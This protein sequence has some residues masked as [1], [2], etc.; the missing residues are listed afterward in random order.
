MNNYSNVRTRASRI[1]THGLTIAAVVLLNI[2][3]A[4][5]STITAGAT[6]GSFDVSPTGAASYNIPI[7]VPPGIAGIAPNLSLNYNSLSGNGLVGMD[8]SIGGLSVITRCP[9]TMAQDGIKEGIQYDTSDVYCLDGQRLVKSSGTYGGNGA[10]YRTERDSFSN[11][12]SYGSTGYGPAWFKVQ[13]KSGQTFEYGHT[14]DSNIMLPGAGGGP[15][16]I[17]YIWSVSKLSDTVGNYLTI[18]YQNDNAIGQYY[19]KRIDYTGNP[20]IIA[21]ET[22]ARLPQSHVDFIYNNDNPVDLRPDIITWYEAGK[23]FNTQVRL[24]NVK[25]YTKVAGVDT[26][27]KNYRLTYESELSHSTERSRLA[28]IEECDGAG[29]VCLNPS[30]LGWQDGGMGFTY[31]TEWITAY[32]QNGWGDDNVTPR[33]LA[34]V[35]GDSLPDIVGFATTG[36]VVSLGTGTGFD[37]PTTWLANAFGANNIQSNCGTTSGGWWQPPVP[38]ITGW[39]GQGA[40]PRMMRDLN[41]DGKADILGFGCSGVVVSYANASGSGFTTPVSLITGTFGGATTGG[42]WGANSVNPRTL[43]DVDG[44]GRPD[45]VGFGPTGVVVSLGTDTGFSTPTPWLSGLGSASGWGTNSVNPRMLSD[46]NGDGKDDIVGFA[47]TGVYV[48]LSTGSPDTGFTAATQWIAAYGQNGW[49]NNSVN[50]RMLSDVNGDG[51]SDIVGF[52]WA[53]VYVSLST[54][55]GFTTATQWNTNYGQSGWANNSVNPRMLVDVNGDGKADIVGFAWDGVYVSL[56]TGST[57]TGFTTAIQWSQAYGQNGWANNTVNPRMLVDVNGDGLPD[58]LG[59][60]Y[61]GTY[62]STAGSLFPD[63][64][65]S[66][67]NGLGAEA[68]ISYKPITDDSVYTMGSGAVYPIR[69]IQAPIYVVSSTSSSNGIGG[70]FVTDYSYANAKVDLSG[71][72]HLGFG[73]TKASNAQSNTTLSTTYNQLYP[74]TGSPA[75]QTNSSTSSGQLLSNTINTYSTAITVA[76]TGTGTT[77]QTPPAV[78]IGMETSEQTSHDLNGA[79]ISRSKTTN[80]YDGYGNPTNISVDTLN[81]MGNS[82]GYNKTTVNTYAPPDLVKWFLS[83]LTNATVSSTSPDEGFIPGA[84]YTFTQTITNNTENY[85]FRADAI[86]SGW[87]QVAPLNA[88]VTVNDGVVIS[89]SSIGTYAFTV[90]G[91]YPVGSTINLLIDNGAY[92][93]GKGGA[94]G[95]GG[96]GVG[97]ASILTAAMYGKPGGPAL[98]I[99]ATDANVTITNNG[100]IAGGG[101]GGGGGAEVNN[102]GSVWNGGGGGGGG[103]GGGAGGQIWGA[104]W[105]GLHVYP[106]VYGNSMGYTCGHPGL[107][108]T[109]IA[110]GTGGAKNPS[111]TLGLRTGAGGN[112]GELGQAGAAG[113]IGDGTASG[114]PSYGYGGGPG[115]S[116]GAATLG[117]ANATWLVTGTRLGAVQ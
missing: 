8:W 35:N 97:H 93:V 115:G 61:S 74:L 65:T 67:T 85:D 62:V 92:I 36:V 52:A 41:N 51:L 4:Q 68:T 76:G 99:L 117:A 38:L 71:R 11:I 112:G 72:G 69:D 102:G 30:E 116:A 49:A 91:S 32:G 57:D 37:A 60:A 63:L 50:P 13:T 21:P 75:S 95:D 105:L 19:P 46:V 54:G 20:N 73:L 82:S 12:T 5:A 107:A 31:E 1:H 87:N 78:F 22:T 58:V 26:P 6:P 109:L 17:S 27:V 84:S 100:T 16:T 114:V 83:Q 70:Q 77:L 48:A 40:Y 64:L 23:Q 110:A 96:P 10:E 43:A 66:V 39:S 24:T 90:A 9:K 104:Y 2:S 94:G 59:F 14:V 89:A 88:T 111:T 101:G 25:T 47:Y 28:N 81:E 86:A 56:S 79:F 80:V 113:G 29:A 108:G 15:G 53:G 98:N 103:A 45:I 18:T 7:A 44:D 34:D 3:L 42:S 106:G 55:T 33:M